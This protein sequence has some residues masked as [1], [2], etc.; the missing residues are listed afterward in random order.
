[1]KNTPYPLINLEA[2]VRELEEQLDFERHLR[3]QLE[4][5][6]RQATAMTVLAAVACVGL[7]LALLHLSTVCTALN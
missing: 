2:Q 4:R 6:A 5:H 1:M 3:H 7:A